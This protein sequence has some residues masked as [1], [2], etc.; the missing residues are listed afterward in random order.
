M[1]SVLVAEIDPG[2]LA[3]ALVAEAVPLA[4][5]GGAVVAPLENRRMERS[6]VGLGLQNLSA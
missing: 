2:I 4:V 3:V 5:G 1:V 6:R